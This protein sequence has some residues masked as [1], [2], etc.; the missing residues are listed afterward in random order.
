M[1]RLVAL[2]IM[3]C[4]GLVCST[5]VLVNNLRK[6]G[7]SG[8][9]YFCPSTRVAAW[10]LGCQLTGDLWQGSQFPARRKQCPAEPQPAWF[11][12]RPQGEPAPLLAVVRADPRPPG[13]GALFLLEV[14]AAP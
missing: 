13:D 3:I 11:C 6:H 10:L 4:G 8:L 2:M 9:G 7:Y 14:A 1:I 12:A 5:S